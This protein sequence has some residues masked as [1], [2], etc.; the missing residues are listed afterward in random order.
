MAAKHASSVRIVFASLIVLISAVW[1]SLPNTTLRR[2]YI[3]PRFMRPD[4]HSGSSKLCI[5]FLAF[6]ISG[7]GMHPN[8]LVRSFVLWWHPTKFLHLSHFQNGNE[9]KSGLW[10]YISLPLVSLAFTSCPHAQQC[11]FISTSTLLRLWLHEG[12]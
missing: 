11:I 9:N 10:G 2:P 5:C 7:V 12:L 6:L 8:G 4:F 3:A 1:Y